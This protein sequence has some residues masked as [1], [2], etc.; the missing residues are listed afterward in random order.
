MGNTQA[1]PG[2]DLT[3]E[4][5]R[6][7][8]EK[9]SYPWMKEV[10]EHVAL[11]SPKSLSN[12]DVEVYFGSWCGDSHEYLPQFF[13]LIDR[14]AK[15]AGVHPKSIKYFGL[16][17]KKTYEGYSNTRSIERIPTFVFLK[18]GREI[19]RIVET[20]RVSIAADTQAILNHRR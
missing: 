10:F 15:K 7:T 14:T 5:S 12:V 16:D 6:T 4:V 17:R 19:G 11:E 18:D 1:S 20:P 8:I 2:T 9:Q 13:S 3:G